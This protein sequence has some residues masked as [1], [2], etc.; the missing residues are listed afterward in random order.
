MAPRPDKESIGGADTCNL[1]GA[2]AVR[3]HRFHP[4][5][6]RDPPPIPLVYVLRAVPEGLTDVYRKP[7]IRS[8][9]STAEPVAA[10]GG[11]LDTDHTDIGTVA[12]GFRQ[13]IMRINRGV[14]G[15]RTGVRGLNKPVRTFDDRCPN[16]AFR[17]TRGRNQKRLRLI[18]R[19]MLVWHELP[20]E[21][22]TCGCD[23]ARACALLRRQLARVKRDICVR[24]RLVP[25]KYGK[26][27]RPRSL[28]PG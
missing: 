14:D 8:A 13:R 27:Q 24:H 12:K 11:K 21:P 25:L 7:A 10:A 20:N 3:G 4:F 22:R 19:T 16:P 2:E 28:R 18:E 23:I 1:S 17:I 5:G 15:Q 6:P 9:R 26:R